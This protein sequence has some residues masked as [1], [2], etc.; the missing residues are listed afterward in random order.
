M[1]NITI[2]TEQMLLLSSLSSLEV[3]DTIT[4]VEL[5]SNLVVEVSLALVKTTSLDDDLALHYVKA[6]VQAGAA[7]TT[8]E[9]MVELS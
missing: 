8:E 6:S 3:A 1:P 9:V 2:L 7:V 4:A 5:N